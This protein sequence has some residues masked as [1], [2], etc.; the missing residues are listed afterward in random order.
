MLE[1]VLALIW[2]IVVPAIFLAPF[3]EHT[4]RE[5]I[6]A[7][8]RQ[9]I[10]DRG[11][12]YV[13]ANPHHRRLFHYIVEYYD[14]EGHLYRTTCRVK[15]FK[16]GKLIYSWSSVSKTLVHNDLTAEYGQLHEELKLLRVKYGDELFVEMSDKERAVWKEVSDKQYE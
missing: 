16:K 13:S 7:Q 2:L 9:Y 5:R 11:G 8:I 1:F 6:R 10:V 12:L 3:I 14:S 15:K 4:N